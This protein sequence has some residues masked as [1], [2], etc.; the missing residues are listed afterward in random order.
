MGITQRVVPFMDWLRAAMVDPQ[1]GIA[2][3]TIMDLANYTL[4]QKQGIR[5]SLAP[6]PP[7]YIASK[8]EGP[9]AAA[10]PADSPGPTARSSKAGNNAIRAVRSGTEDPPSMCN[11]SMAEQL[12]DTW[13]T[14]SPLKKDRARAATE[15]DFHSTIGSLCYR[16]PMFPQRRHGHGYRNCVQYQIPHRGGGRAQHFL[17]PQPIPLRGSEAALL[18]RNWGT[19]LG[20]GTLTSFA[21]TSMLMGKKKVAPITGQDESAS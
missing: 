1:Q 2:A 5:T 18:K 7:C 16:P 10:V 4:A 21:D 20:G 14:V 17:V 15:K 8:P 9:G 11:I 19:I 13:R 12:P 3:L 6:P